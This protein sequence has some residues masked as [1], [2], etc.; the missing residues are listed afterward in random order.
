MT[1]MPP[2]WL[3][4]ETTPGMRARLSRSI[5]VNDAVSPL[6]VLR[7][8]TQFGPHKRK[9]VLRQTAASSSCFSAPSRP[10]SA[11]PPAHATPDGTPAATQSRTTSTTLSAGT[12]ITARSG[13]PGRSRRLA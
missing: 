2:L 5:V 12:A 7:S 3:T 1:A 6:P 8:P 10:T 11:K 9:P 4:I 13:V